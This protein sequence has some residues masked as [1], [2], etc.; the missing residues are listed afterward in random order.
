MKLYLIRHAETTDNLSRFYAGSRDSPLTLHGVTQARLLAHHFSSTRPPLTHIFSS[1]LSRAHKTALALRD[2]QHQNVLEVIVVPELRERDFGLEEGQP[3]GR[4]GGSGAGGEDNKSVGMRAEKFLDGYLI[5]L[6]QSG[7]E[8]EVAVV[9]HG[10][11]LSHLWRKLLQHLSRER[12]LLGPAIAATRGDIEEGGLEYLGT[13]SN[14]GY[15]ELLLSKDSLAAQN[16]ATQ[17]PIPFPC[18]WTATILAVDNKSHLAGLK[19][20]RGGIGRLAHDERQ[21]KLESF[22]PSKRLKAG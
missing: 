16:P 15:L 17:E 7:G 5:P 12:V 1:P 8:E 10:I 11:L 14:T 20:Q 21:R 3:Y 22:F 4:G 19:R 2:A 9:S 18:G 6:L 13:W